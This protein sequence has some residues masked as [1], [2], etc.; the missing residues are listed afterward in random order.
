[1]QQLSSLLS[2]SLF[3]AQYVSGVLPPIIRSSM[4][5]VK[6]QAATAVVELLMMGGRT[7]ETCWAVNKCQDNKFENCCIWLVIYLNLT[8]NFILI[9]LGNLS[10]S[11]WR[12]YEH[13]I[14]RCSAMWSGKVPSN[15][16]IA[17]SHMV[18]LFTLSAEQCCIFCF[19]DV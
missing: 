2:W 18:E 13:C 12:L 10:V 14:L 3:T 9:F 6:L 17:N 19:V 11:L 1:M 8:I 5:T 15:F 4:T 16:T 7:P